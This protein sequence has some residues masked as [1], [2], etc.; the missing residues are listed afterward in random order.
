MV[1]KCGFNVLYFH[2]T[3]IVGKITWAKA[4]PVN[5]LPFRRNVKFVQ[6]AQ[7][8]GHMGVVDLLHHHNDRVNR[9]LHRCKISCSLYPSSKHIYKRAAA[10]ISHTRSYIRI[11]PAA[12]RSIAVKLHKPWSQAVHFHVTVALNTATRTLSIDAYRTAVLRKHCFRLPFVYAH[13]TMSTR[14]SSHFYLG[15]ISEVQMRLYTPH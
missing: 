12:R 13:C 1:C 11:P 2:C 6:Y 5:A 7:A 4:G 8:M 9:C 3:S 14:F 15:R 10:C